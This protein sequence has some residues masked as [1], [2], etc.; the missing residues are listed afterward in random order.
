MPWLAAQLAP[1]AASISDRAIAIILAIGL[2]AVFLALVVLIWTRWGQARPLAKCIGLSGVAHLLLLIYA[3][4]TRVLFDQP[5]H[6]TGQT[7][8]IHLA[9]PRDN[10]EAAPLPELPEPMPWEQPGIDDT[11]ELA[12]ATPDRPPLPVANPR[13]AE[14][15]PV[16]IPP[17]T[18]AP[19]ALPAPPLARDPRS[20]SPPPLLPDK[21]ADATPADVP[22]AMP[23]PQ[24][25]AG[26]PDELTSP[27]PDLPRRGALPE[28]PSAATAAAPANPLREATPPPPPPPAAETFAAAPATVPRR[29]GDGQELP[30]SLRARNVADRLKV[31]QQFGGTPQTEAAVAA[32]L[33]WLANNQSPD[34]RWDADRH[35]AGRETRTLGHDRQG[36]GARADTGIT[37]LA[38]LAFLGSGETHLEGKHRESVQHGLEFLLGSQ[39]ASGSLAGD[40]ELFAAMYSHGI[41]TLALGEAYAMTGDERLLPGLRRAI[42]YTLDSQH[43]GGGWR[44]QPGDTG[45]ISQFGWQL[46]ALRSAELGGLP[47]PVETRTR[48]AR[49]LRSASS[50]P[51]KGLAS[52][53]P[54]DRASR[55]M[56]AEALACRYFLE[57]ENAPATLHEAARYVMDEPPGDGQTNLYFWY[58]GTLAMFQ[59]QGPDWERWNAGLQKQ[60]LHSQRFDGEFTG[61]WDPD[62]LWGG[63]GGRV[64]GTAVAALCLEVYYRYLPTHGNAPADRERLTDR[65][66]WPGVPR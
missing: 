26:I 44:Y 58:Y 59:R 28:P 17:P 25:V 40:A 32:A 65:Q 8:K 12:I 9:E 47:M 18:P 19:R 27:L 2:V 46:M 57:A 35:G 51:A 1:D 33:D 15:P 55:T 64:Y 34:G 49:F 66:G 4:S 56:T 38:L 21:P 29:L 45:D 39:V 62:P 52:Y 31:A 6:W 30:E 41:A 43:A 5:G 61:S 50:G 48:M 37:G 3:Y 7:V 53:R 36:A 23:M 11:A 16:E 13:R 24:A 60:L 42:R 22:L 63:Y 14:V 10:E 20:V 54:G